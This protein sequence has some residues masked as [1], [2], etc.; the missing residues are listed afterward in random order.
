MTSVTSRTSADRV[1]MERF[2]KSVQRECSL[3][4]EFTTRREEIKR[5]LIDFC[6]R[7]KEDCPVNLDCEVKKTYQSLF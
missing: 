1:E 6:R 5:R 3:L 7:C 4:L 2:C